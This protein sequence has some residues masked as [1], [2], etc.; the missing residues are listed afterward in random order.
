[1]RI[2]ISVPDHIAAKAQRAVDGGDADSVSAYFSAL[3][4][5]EPDWASARAAV[6]QMI[7]EAGGLTP[8]GEQW[9]DAVIFG[10]AADEDEL[11][12]GA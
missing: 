2:T 12:R 6:D 11:R 10:D 1:M 5:R 7:A 9:V 3:A 8:E 4:E